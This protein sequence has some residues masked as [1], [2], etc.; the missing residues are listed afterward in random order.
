MRRAQLNETDMERV[1]QEEREAQAAWMAPNARLIRRRQR[2]EAAREALQAQ[3]EQAGGQFAQR[4]RTQERAAL[5]QQQQSGT[6][7]RSN[8]VAPWKGADQE[9]GGAVEH[10]AVQAFDGGG[11]GKGGG[12][13]TR[14]P[15]ALLDAGGG[16]AALQQGQYR[17][18]LAHL[19]MAQHSGQGD[20]AAR[21]HG[22]RL[23]GGKGT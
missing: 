3:P 21:P 23:P 2:R 9:G 8:Q 18:D 7:S 19:A 10:T 11:G 17:T 20:Q 14:Q 13:G 1:E 6:P 16:A 12:N 4:L 22:A 5:V 15:A